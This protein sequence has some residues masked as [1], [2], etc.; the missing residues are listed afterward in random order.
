MTTSHFTRSAAALIVTS[1]LVACGGGGGDNAQPGDPV[2]PGNPGTPP[3]VPAGTPV[4]YTAGSTAAMALDMVNN[5]IAHC[6]YNR[7]TPALDLTNAAKAHANYEALNGFPTDHGE[8]P[9]RPGF[10]GVTIFERIVAA[11]ASSDRANQTSEGIG[12]LGGSNGR[13]TTALLAAPFHQ[14]DLLSQ[15][16]E[17]GIGSTPET[18]NPAGDTAAVVFNYGGS[19]LNT[20]PMN[21]VRSFPCD[22][23][24]LISSQGGPE[25]PDP[26]PELGGKFGP[27]LNF[28]TNKD[29]AITVTSLSLRNESTGDMIP[30]VQVKTHTLDGL[31]W[32]SMWISKGYLTP[33]T[34][35]RVEARGNTYPSKNFNDTATPW[36]KNYS[37]TTF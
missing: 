8:N 33:K 9:G 3:T 6:G 14:A 11:G 27:G 23:S 18:L 28:E 34:T 5:A 26:A 2:N 4:S 7:M 13:V 24:T 25:K 1:L 12:T 32:R 19:R 16:T 15:W 10:T 31:L 20:V 37:F 29:G 22:G 30:V 17:I 21:S 36:S 35:Y